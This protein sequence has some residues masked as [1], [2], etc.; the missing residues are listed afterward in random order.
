MKSNIYKIEQDI[1]VGS[2]E[3]CYLI[4]YDATIYVR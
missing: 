1:Y 4:D 3:I 2:K